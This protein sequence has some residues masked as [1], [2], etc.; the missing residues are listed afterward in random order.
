M[1]EPP[2]SFAPASYEDWRREVESRRGEGALERLRSETLDGILVAPLYGRETAPP[3]LLRPWKAAAGWETWGTLGVQGGESRVQGTEEER[4]QGEGGDPLD[5]AVAT[6]GIEE[7]WRLGATGVRLDLAGP[8]RPEELIPVLQAAVSRNV[9]IGVAG[10]ASAAILGAALED[11]ASV[12]GGSL[13]LDAVAVATSPDLVAEILGWMPEKA[14]GARAFT[15]SAETPDDVGAGT[16]L[17]LA[18]MAAGALELLRA[19]ERSGIDPRAVLERSEVLLAVG[20]DVHLQIAKLRAARILWSMVVASLGVAPQEAPLRLVARTSWRTKTRWDAK[21][22]LLRETL[23]S[24]AAVVGGCDVLL[25][26]PFDGGATELGRRLRLTLPLVLRDEARLAEVADP[27]GGSWAL[28]ALTGRLAEETWNELQR[29]EGEGGLLQSLASGALAARMER[30]AEGRRLALRTRREPVT[31]ISLHPRQES[32]PVVSHE[33]APPPRR[34]PSG[35]SWRRLLET[36]RHGDLAAVEGLLQPGAQLT[37]VVPW[38]DGEL[39]E[40][41]RDR[42]AVRG[43]TPRAVLVGIGSPRE[44]SAPL[45]FARQLLVAGGFG[46]EPEGPHES[47]EKAAAAIS[48]SDADLVVLVLPPEA[49]VARRALA[50]DAMGRARRGPIAITGREEVAGVRHRLYAGADAVATLEAL[51]QEVAP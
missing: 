4:G 49:E 22:N 16:V 41:F 18:W 44:V 17:E 2:P 14:P 35:V 36:A 24:F 38:S 3:P 34:V 31:G 43:R 21:T 40:R 46:V 1:T 13:G 51:W 7:I 28:E 15:V 11:G 29:I 45:G 9:S 47:V 42:A 50:V 48:G 27:A 5:G 33:P 12:V 6:A 19:A 37:D 39:F 23:E 10:V 25:A 30:V 20:R 26:R 32:A 8:V